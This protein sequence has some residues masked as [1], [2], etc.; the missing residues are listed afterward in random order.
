MLFLLSLWWSTLCTPFLIIVILIHDLLLLGIEY[1]L[2]SSSSSLQWSRW[3]TS[4]LL[5]T[6]E[7]MSYSS[8]SSYWWSIWSTPHPPANN[9]THILVLISSSWSS[10]QY[11]PHFPLTIEYVVYSYYPPHDWLHSRPILSS[12]WWSTRPTHCLPCDHDCTSNVP[13]HHP[14]FLKA[15]YAFP[16][17]NLLKYIHIGHTTGHHWSLCLVLIW[18]GLSILQGYYHN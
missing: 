9:E 8:Y 15:V 18:G 13:H 10:T 2:H 5:L 3:S 4:P 12:L 11:T 14:W 17:S 7:H 16:S 1:T 6:I